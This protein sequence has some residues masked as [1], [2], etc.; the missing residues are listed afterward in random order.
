MVASIFSYSNAVFFNQ[1]SA[2]PIRIPPVVSG[3]LDPFSRLSVNVFVVGAPPNP[4]AP[5]FPS[6]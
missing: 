5:R 4:A 6:W 3:P 2:E 1:D